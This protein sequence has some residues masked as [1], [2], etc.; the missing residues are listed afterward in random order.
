VH[1][2]L[3]ALIHK[4]HT[5]QVLEGLANHP[6]VV[7]AFV[8][9]GRSNDLFDYR[10]FGDF[11][12]ASIVTVIAEQEASDEILDLLHSVCGLASSKE[13]VVFAGKP[14]V[15]TSLSA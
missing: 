7:V 9:G 14:L 12:E 10:E 3:G 4:A 8:A 6:S 1:I 15:K 2:E 13:G 11:G 5:E